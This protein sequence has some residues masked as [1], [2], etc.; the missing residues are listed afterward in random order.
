MRAL[1][2]EHLWKVMRYL[3]RI[4]RRRVRGA[5]TSAA[6]ARGIGWPNSQTP[7]ACSVTPYAASK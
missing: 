6:V 1:L 7:N 4:D 2:P 3:D 5:V